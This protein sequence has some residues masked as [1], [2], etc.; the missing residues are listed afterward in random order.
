MSDDRALGGGVR[1][2]AIDQM[3]EGYF[4]GTTKAVGTLYREQL[5]GHTLILI[6]SAIETCGLLDAPSEQQSATG[7]TFKDWVKKYM[8]TFPGVE[9][10]EI[11]LW[12]ARCAVVHTFTSESDLSKSGLA[13]ELLYYTGDKSAS[14]NQ[15]LLAFAKRYEGG[16]QLPVR[17]ED[18]CEAF[19]Q[20]MKEFVQV[21]AA[22]CASSQPHFDRLRRVLQTHVHGIPPNR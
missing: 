9:F 19:F 1:A 4:V 7:Q 3:L 11:E 10:S 18:L 6:Y 21:L 14:H 13:R 8:L 17:F 16:K 12:A 5:L 22:N 2:Q 15:E 20:G